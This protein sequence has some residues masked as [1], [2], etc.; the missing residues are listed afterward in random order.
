LLITNVF[1]ET[2][3]IK[4]FSHLCG[5]AEKSDMLEIT[6]WLELHIPLQPFALRREF[7]HAAALKRALLHR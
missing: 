6:P 4:P 3:F 7:R 5:T 2:I 1:Q